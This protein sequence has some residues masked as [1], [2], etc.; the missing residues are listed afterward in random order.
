[1]TQGPTWKQSRSK[2]SAPTERTHMSEQSKLEDGDELP[3]EAG[4]F[5]LESDPPEDEGNAE[6][7]N[8]EE[9]D[10]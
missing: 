3:P 4:T 2:L 10:G 7:E 1:V 8:K 6:A 5:P 9:N